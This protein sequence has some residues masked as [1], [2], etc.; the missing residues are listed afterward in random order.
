M[1]RV[2][3]EWRSSGVPFG[4]AVSLL[5]IVRSNDSAPELGVSSTAAEKGPKGQVKSGA[6][7]RLP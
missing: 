6:A 4:H 7:S 5:E 2:Q 3:R 1:N